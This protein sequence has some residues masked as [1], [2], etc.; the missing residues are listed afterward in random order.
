MSTLIYPFTFP[1]FNLLIFEGKRWVIPYKNRG[2]GTQIIFLSEV[3][4][5]ILSPKNRKNWLQSKPLVKSSFHLSPV[6]WVLSVASV[7]EPGLK[8]IS[9][10]SLYITKGRSVA[11]ESSW[12]GKFMFGNWTTAMLTPHT[13]PYTVHGRSI[14]KVFGTDQSVNSN[15]NVRLVM[16]WANFM[17]HLWA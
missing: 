5:P 6:P 9:V 17:N 2:K 4:S 10:P 16:K 15:R 7:K 14:V 13:H 8:R 12:R 3:I 11:F 1:S